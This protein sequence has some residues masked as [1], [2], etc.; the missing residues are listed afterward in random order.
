MSI[1]KGSQRVV[2][3]EDEE[4]GERE[5]VGEGGGRGADGAGERDGGRQEGG[6][7]GLGEA[8]SEARL[9]DLWTWR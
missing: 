2:E 4:A 9:A 7:G 6:V 3:V 5:A 1:Q 8:D